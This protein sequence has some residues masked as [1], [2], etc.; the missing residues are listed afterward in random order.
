MPHWLDDFKLYRFY[1]FDITFLS[2]SGGIGPEVLQS[3]PYKRLFV[4]ISDYFSVVVQSA[5]GMQNI[6]QKQQQ[7]TKTGVTH[8]IFQSFNKCYTCP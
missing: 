2:L 1:R 5:I 7:Q 4:C 3:F 8:I 6:I